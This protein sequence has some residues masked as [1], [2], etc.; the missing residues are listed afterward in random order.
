M[1]DAVIDLGS[2][3]YPLLCGAVLTQWMKLQV[4]CSSLLPAVV[5]ATLGR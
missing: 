2:Y 4:P 3:A 5:V 1:R